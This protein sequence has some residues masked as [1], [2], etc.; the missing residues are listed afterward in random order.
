V[1]KGIDLLLAL[2]G[3]LFKDAAQHPDGR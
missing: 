2:Q 3:D 1:E